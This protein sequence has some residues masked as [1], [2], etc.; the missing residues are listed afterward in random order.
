MTSRN[1][2][3]PQID[4]SVEADGWPE[5]STLNPVIENSILA[6]AETASLNWPDGA[7]LSIL[8]TSD[9]AMTEINGQ[10]RGKSRPTNVLSFPGSDIVPGKSA[11]LVIGDLVFALETVQREAAEQGK[12]FE[13][14]FTHLSVHGFL[15]LFGYDHLEEVEAERMEGLEIRVLE[16][17]GITNPYA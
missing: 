16:G 11:G 12:T 8:L 1:S 3:L 17:L 6:A 9:A 14:H 4:I 2:H 15:H 5:L 13:D 10:W 7:E